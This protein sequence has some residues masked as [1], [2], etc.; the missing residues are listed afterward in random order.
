[1]Y[2]SY[3]LPFSSNDS[4]TALQKHVTA[5]N[6]YIYFHFYEGASGTILYYVFT[7]LNNSNVYPKVGYQHW[8]KTCNEKT[9]EGKKEGDGD[10][11]RSLRRTW[12]LWRGKI[13]PNKMRVS[14][15]KQIII[16]KE[17]PRRKP[18]MES[19]SPMNAENCVFYFCSGCVYIFSVELW[20]ETTQQLIQSHVIS[21]LRT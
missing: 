12:E 9:R 20:T 10:W 21:H 13:K 15:R 14:K 3:L 2:V 17:I 16:R 5:A 4:I 1:M 19:K 18:S 11:T 8:N 6:K 7:A